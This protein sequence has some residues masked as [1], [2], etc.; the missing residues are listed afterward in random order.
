MRYFS[1]VFSEKCQFPADSVSFVGF[2]IDKVRILTDP[3][4]VSA[5]ADLNSEAITMFSR[6]CQ[7]LLEVC[8]VKPDALSWLFGKE[9][10][11]GESLCSILPPL[12]IV[13]SLSWEIKQRVRVAGPSACPPNFLY[14]PLDLRLEVLPWAHNSRLNCYPRIQ[15]TR[16]AL[17]PMLMVA[18]SGKGHAGICEDLPILCS[19]ES[20]PVASTDFVPLP[21]L[22][23]ANETAQLI[24][25]HVFRLRGILINL[26][27][28]RGPQFVYV[29]WKELCSQLGAM[30]TLYLG[31]IPNPMARQSV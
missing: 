11:Q 6:Y 2:I 5:V 13:A 27:L 9:N 23:S 14:V 26:V 12:C 19:K 25:R 15:W 4:K 18:L 10:A 7:F 1:L 16:G 29:F 24:L 21:R 3:A 8:N 28:D 17:L 31:T 22:P 30:A 20:A